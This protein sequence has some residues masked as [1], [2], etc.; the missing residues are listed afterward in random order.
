MKLYFSESFTVIN[1]ITRHRN[2]KKAMD[3]DT[4]VPFAPGELDW[5]TLAPAATG[6]LGTEASEMSGPVSTHRGPAQVSPGSGIL[7]A[8]NT[9]PQVPFLVT[10]GA[11]DVEDT[12]P[13]Y[14][15][16]FPSV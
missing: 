8:L 13:P 4:C 12:D 3:I 7:P 1:F 9:E 11:I 16:L 5:A 2:S 6:G 15:A 10:I 14:M